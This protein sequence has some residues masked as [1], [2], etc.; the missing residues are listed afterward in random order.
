MIYQRH[1][2]TPVLFCK[3]AAE[4]FDDIKRPHDYYQLSVCMQQLVAK[5]A[6]LLSAVLS[7]LLP[8]FDHANGVPS[9]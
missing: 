9:N 7:A 1:N 5:L 4:P 3:V 2:S 6:T 8:L